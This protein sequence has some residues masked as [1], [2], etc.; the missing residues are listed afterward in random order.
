MK[1]GACLFILIVLILS[2]PSAGYGA[3][4]EEWALHVEIQPE[5]P[6]IYDAIDIISSGIRGS[7]PVDVET[8]YFQ[9]DGTN[10]TLN[11]FINVGM[12]TVITPWTYTETIGTL[13][14][15]IYDLSVTAYYDYGSLITTEDY[16]TSFEVDVPEPA[17][18]L[19]LG[20]GG[21]LIRKR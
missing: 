9:V 7:G 8:T 12:L 14:A 10:L 16:F 3:P 6:T 5:T 19:L 18:L 13:P 11:M 21:L 20:L 15:G 17:T 4:T 1:R 2:F